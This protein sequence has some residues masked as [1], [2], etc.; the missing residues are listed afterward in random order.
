VSVE[1]QHF[2]V[3]NQHWF[4]GNT[5]TNLINIFFASY[6]LYNFLVLINKSILE[7]FFFY[8]ARYLYNR[9]NNGLLKIQKKQKGG[10]EF[11][12]RSIY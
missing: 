11:F 3:E 2:S 10:E 9:E 7:L 6:L 4:C 8:L 12:L 5:I 1:S